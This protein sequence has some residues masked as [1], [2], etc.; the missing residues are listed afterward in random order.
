ME[1]FPLKG[2]S[3][4]N[5]S[6]I[7]LTNSSSVTTYRS[8]DAK[9]SNGKESNSPDNEWF[10]NRTVNRESNLTSDED[11]LDINHHSSPQ[12]SENNSISDHGVRLDDNSSHIESDDIPG[13]GQYE[14]FHTIDW[15]RDIARD[16]MRHR[17][18]VKKRHDSIWGLIKGAHDAWSGW[19]CVLLV[20]L[21]TGVA[22]GVIDIGASWMSDLKFGICPQMFWLNKEQCCWSYNET[23]FD[24]A[25]CTQWLTWPEIFSR[26]KEGAGA[27]TISYIFFIAWALL[28]ASLSAS[29]V[30]MFAPYACGSGIPEIKTILSGFIIRGYLGKWTLIIKSVGLILSV[31]AGLSL[32]KEGP[33]VH[34][35]CCIGNIFSYLFPK[36]GRNEAK[37]REILSAAAAAGVSVAFGAPIG[38]VLFSLEEVSYYFPLKTL[39]RSFFCA[40]I[41]AFV[42]R[43]INPFG[44][45]HSVLFFVEYNKPWIFF[46]LIPFVILG[47]IGGVIATLFIKANL[48]WCQYRK[49]SKLG[50]YPVTEVLVVTL[51]TAV[52]GYP[53]PYTRMNTSQ[54]IYLLFSQCGVSNSDMLCDY[55]RNFT[56]VKSA[57]EIAAAGPGVYNAIWLLVLALIL[58]LIMTIFTFGMKVPCGLFIPSLCLGAITGRIVGIGMEQLAYNY[59]HIW[60][61]SEECSTGVDCI[62]PGL[63]AMVGAAAVLGGVTR[64]TVSLVVIMFELT[65]GV[66]Y[67]GMLYPRESESR[68][69]KSLDGLW[70]FVVSP[71]EDSLKGYR[72]AWFTNNLS[73]DNGAIKMPVPSSYNDI[74]T[75]KIL[76]DH[77]GTVWYQRSFFV[78]SSW[79]GQRVF[80]RFGSVNYLAQVWVNGGLA[81]NHEMGHLPFEVEISS[82]LVYGGK[83][84]ITVAV[85]N[86]LLQTSVPQGKVVDATTDNGTTHLQTYTFDFF[87]YAGIHRP[88][89]LHTKPRVFIEDITIRTGLVG[90]MGIIKYIVQTA[91]LHEDEIVTCKVSLVD[92]DD[93]LASK[94]QSFTLS[95][96]IKVP[97]ARLWWPRG[98]DPQPGYLYTLEVRISVGNSSTVDVYR[99][100]I[101]IR[102]LAWT[103]TS[104]LI[105]ERPVYLKG[106][107]RHE[108]SAIRGRGFDLVTMIR[109]HELLQWVGANA[110][111]TSHYPY[112][113]EVL[114]TTD[115]L[116]ILIIDECPSVDTENFSPILLNRHKESL[117]ELVRRD[118]NR[119]SV[120][121]WSIA[122][123]PRT[124][125]AQAEEYFK[126]IAHH[127]KTIDPTRPVTIALARG[128]SEDKA[129]KYLDIISFNRYNSWYS[130]TG[131]LDMVTDRVIAEAQA[132]HKKYGKPVLMSEYGADTMPGLHELPEYVWS[133]EYQT[134]LLSRHFKAFDQLRNEG[135]FIGE[136]IWNF[137]DFRTA[138][139]YT[140]VGGNKKG[141]FTRD[142][143]PKMA[144]HHVRKRYHSLEFELHGTEMPQ[145]IQRYVAPCYNQYCEL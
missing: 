40:L 9:R 71:E 4:A 80:I 29:L 59:P 60:M 12:Y 89:L 1:K 105:N 103:D 30:R 28:F 134:E 102:T 125:L 51:I 123:E 74:T 131:R 127:T 52:I 16:R 63:Y 2:T 46:E 68:E 38:G 42:L 45:E 133:E 104:L 66:R 49:T 110:Y 73:K 122:N 140:R 36:Y 126:Q 138:Q 10:Q 94:E 95:G 48:Y 119:P 114:D 136:F 11:M 35:A 57:I 34:I 143:Q 69:V 90:D 37:K 107:G 100:P 15:Q 88:V 117:S 65:G 55:N 61:F 132:W 81:T 112:S 93:T 24:G 77:V 39:W 50:Q 82:Y 43:S 98:M 14:D 79:M 3:S 75:S 118:K 111:R 5:N 78:P 145:D 91:G 137:A 101:G 124:Q 76:R 31:S 87:N 64:M 144:A 33:M 72:E 53:N 135:F 85:D 7:P 17:Y 21:F 62:T 97:N 113:D 54:L 129:G 130:N 116:G 139:S 19:L 86:T 27:Y 58:K 115:R 128:V 18:I 6:A 120:I 8:V 32:G 96:T 108:D 25:N 106:F 99:L 141:I 67:T 142:R 92:A 22:A 121:M 56:A 84:W 23:T 70:D 83:N 13:I 26:S 41:A 44:N 109:D 20:G 47:I